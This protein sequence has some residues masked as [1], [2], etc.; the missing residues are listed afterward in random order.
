MGE[1]DVSQPSDAAELRRFTQHL[2]ADVRAF[3][4]MLDNEMFETGVSRI[5]AEQELF[6]VDAAHR[7]APVSLK[8]L[9]AIDD[10]HFTTELAS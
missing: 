1:Q 10:P 9:E 6:L 7:P 2:L 3:Q 8:V 5:G 4:Q